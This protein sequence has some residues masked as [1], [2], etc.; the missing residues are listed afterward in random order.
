MNM[1]PFKKL[2]I[3]YSLLVFN[4]LILMNTWYDYKL[5]TRMSFDIS[6]GHIRNSC[7]KCERPNGKCG[8]A[9]K[10]FCHP[11]ECSE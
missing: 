9:L 10:C 11:K 6:P 4:N 7:K 2:H 1:N 5:G 3:L 8:R